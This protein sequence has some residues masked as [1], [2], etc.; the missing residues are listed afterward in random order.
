MYHVPLFMFFL[1]RLQTVLFSQQLL[2]QTS[3]DA[4]VARKSEAQGLQCAEACKCWLEFKRVE[5]ALYSLQMQRESNV[6]SDF[7][8]Y[9]FLVVLRYFINSSVWKQ[10]SFINLS[11]QN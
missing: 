7:I 11:A 5:I 3:W 8:Y 2:Y 6:L 9:M 1:V 10:N 4:L